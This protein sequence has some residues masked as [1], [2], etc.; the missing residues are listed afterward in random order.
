[1]P[2]VSYN[3]YWYPDNGGTPVSRTAYTRT[4][5]KSAVVTTANHALRTKRPHIWLPPTAMS[6][7][8]DEIKY[9]YM[10]QKRSGG[11]VGGSGVDNA[12]YS[13]PYTSAYDFAG[14][15]NA[16]VI[17]ALNN[18][19]DQKVNFAQAFA[20]R[21]QVASL[22]ANT[23][24]KL[25]KAARAI[26]RGDVPGAARAL[27]I[28]SKQK[29]KGVRESWLE[30]QYGWKPLLSD[31]YGSMCELHDNDV[32]EPQRYRFTVRGSASESVSALHYELYGSNRYVAQG[33]LKRHRGARVRLD[34]RLDN[35]MLAA[36][37][38]LGLT[39]PAQLAWE[40]VPWSFVADWFI[41]VGSYLSAMD[42]D[43]GYIFQGGSVTTRQE[44]VLSSLT[45]DI[46]AL[47]LAQTNFTKYHAYGGF[48]SQKR[49]IR[50]VYSSSPFPRF[51]GFKN[52]FSVTHALNAIALLGSAVH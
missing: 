35:P 27:G 43:L 16:A 11:S 15:K 3:G 10:Y 2:T 49:V 4:I 42:A 13:I 26:R 12:S 23:A 1:M 25:A 45:L 38:A 52:P 44:D 39:N 9:F 5:T 50:T 37:S 32:A 20:E 33:V 34:Y 31:V 28:T 18:L 47:G 8:T 24:T 19:K 17:R 29:F 51:P 14:L 6:R 21:G 30:L 40:L 36:A 48:R 7:E 41:P 46:T 22:V